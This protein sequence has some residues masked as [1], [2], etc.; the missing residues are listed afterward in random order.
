M[1]RI[2]KARRMRWTGHVARMEKMKAYRMLV[3]KPEGRRPLA[4]SRL[5]WF[6][7]IRIDLCAGGL[8]GCGLDWSGSG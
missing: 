1:I 8:G 2:I 4:R 5:R 3:G 7:N 6:D